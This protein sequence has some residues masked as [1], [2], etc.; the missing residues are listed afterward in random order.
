M[1]Q[2]TPLPKTKTFL[3]FLFDT[4]S[5]GYNELYDLNAVRR[6]QRNKKVTDGH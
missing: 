2:P 5:L 1:Q 6:R 3:G 4:V